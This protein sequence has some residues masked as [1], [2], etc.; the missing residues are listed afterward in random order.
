MSVRKDGGFIELAEEAHGL[1]S[2]S[3]SHH[4]NRL[5]LRQRCTPQQYNENTIPLEPKL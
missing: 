1:L 3:C 2:L 4:P 5:R